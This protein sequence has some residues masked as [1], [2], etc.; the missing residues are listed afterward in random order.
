MSKKPTLRQEIEVL[1]KL[2]TE[3][4]GRIDSLERGIDSIKGSLMIESRGHLDA[5]PDILNEI[6]RLRAFVNKNE[7]REQIS[8]KTIEILER[9]LRV[10]MKDETLMRELELNNPEYMRYI[11]QLN[12]DNNDIC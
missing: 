8:L 6:T 10:S 9:L 1:N 2:I 11:H 7:A 3:K 5:I 4:D 12:R